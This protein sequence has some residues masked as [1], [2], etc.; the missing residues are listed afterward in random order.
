[1]PGCLG[2]VGGVRSETDVPPMV[3][4]HRQGY[5]VDRGKGWTRCIAMR[6]LEENHNSYSHHSRLTRKRLAIC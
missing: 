4:P 3:S 1:M 6:G 5:T 2:L